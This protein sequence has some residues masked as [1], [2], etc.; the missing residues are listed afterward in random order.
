M[1]NSQT[2]TSP[3]RAVWL[4]LFA[5]VMLVAVG[6]RRIFRA[7]G[8]MNRQALAAIDVGS[9]E[10]QW[11]R[12]ERGS[13]ET[14]QSTLRPRADWRILTQDEHV[15]VLGALAPIRV[16]DDTAPNLRAEGFRDPWGQMYRFEV[17][18]LPDGMVRVRATSAGRDG[19]FGTADDLPELFAGPRTTAPTAT[20][21]AP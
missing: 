9:L 12:Y 10:E 17:R 2:V 21:A 8:E 16:N 15:W 13:R 6:G 11:V 14:A 5:A 1:T 20:Q 4:I 3:R 18:Q 7:A 19:Q